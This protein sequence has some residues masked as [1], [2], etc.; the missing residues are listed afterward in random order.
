MSV[1]TVNKLLIG[2]NE[3]FPLFIVVSE[4]LKFRMVRKTMSLQELKVCLVEGMVVDGR[5]GDRR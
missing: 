5:D 3:F 1:C 4:R 2:R